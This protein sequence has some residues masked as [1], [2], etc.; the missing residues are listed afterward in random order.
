MNLINRSPAVHFFL[1]LIAPVAGLMPRTVESLRYLLAY[2]T[3]RRYRHP[4][5]AQD[6]IMADYF[7]AIAKSNIP[8][9]RYGKAGELDSCA[10]FLAAPTS[11]YVNGQNIAVDG[12][13]TCV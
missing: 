1:R 12:G 11:T 7:Q 10:I 2:K 13:Y 9:Q 8:L 4:R 6:R 3:R 5:D